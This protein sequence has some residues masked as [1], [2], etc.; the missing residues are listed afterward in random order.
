MTHDL[1]NDG[2]VGD[3]E[4]EAGAASASGV[5][6]PCDAA[7]RAPRAPRKP[8]EALSGYPKI[9]QGAPGGGRVVWDRGCEDVH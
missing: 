2:R 7:T 5:A 3:G 9:V 8:Q 6:T 1:T 4:G